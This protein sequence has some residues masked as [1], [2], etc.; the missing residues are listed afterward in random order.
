[1]TAACS[2]SENHILPSRY[3]TF[4]WLFGVLSIQP[5]KEEEGEDSVWAVFTGQTSEGPISVLVI[6]HWPELHHRETPH[7]RDTGK[8]SPAVSEEE[9]VSDIP[10][11]C[12]SLLQTLCRT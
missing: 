10:G 2:H 11:N 9:W 12:G 5:G 4:L 7:A 3:P 6:F 1:M 8:C